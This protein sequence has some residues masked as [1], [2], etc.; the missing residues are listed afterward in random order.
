M[1]DVYICGNCIIYVMRTVS[2]DEDVT[3]F[4][5]LLYLN[6]GCMYLV[7]DVIISGM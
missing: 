7:W 6:V 2:R 5:V 4:H 1:W 3:L